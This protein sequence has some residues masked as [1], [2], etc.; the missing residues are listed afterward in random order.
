MSDILAE[1]VAHKRGEVA[2]AKQATPLESLLPRVPGAPP[3]R[4]FLGALRAEGLT[5]VIAE[6]KRAAARLN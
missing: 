3:V 5:R 2:A 1:I 6:L 4:D